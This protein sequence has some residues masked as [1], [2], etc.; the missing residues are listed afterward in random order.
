MTNKATPIN[1]I[2]YDGGLV[3]LLDNVPYY[4]HINDS[5]PSGYY[6]QYEKFINGGYQKTTTNGATIHWVKNKETDMWSILTDG[7]T[8]YIGIQQYND[9]PITFAVSKKSNKKTPKNEDSVTTAMNTIA[10]SLGSV[11]TQYAIPKESETTKVQSFGKKMASTSKTSKHKP[12]LQST[13]HNVAVKQQNANN[14]PVVKGKTKSGNYKYDYT[15]S[16]QQSIKDDIDK[17]KKNLNA[18]SAYSRLELNKLFHKKFNRFRIQFPD[19]FLHNTTPCVIFTRPDLNL[20]D[21]DGVMLDQVA[22]DPQFYYIMR[23]DLLT[24]KTLTKSFTGEHHFNPLLSNII[25]SLDIQ[26]ESIDLMETGETFTGFKTQYAKSNIRSLTANTMNIRFPE[27]Y[28]MSITHCHQLWCTYESNVFRGVMKPKMKYVWNKELDYACD[29]YYFLLDTEDSI[30][31]YWCKYTGC[32]PVSVPKSVFSYDN[33]TVINHPEL[34]ITYAY[35]AREDLDLRTLNEFNNNAGGKTSG[36]R[37][38]AD[39]IPELG[40][41]GKTWSGAPFVET[42]YRQNGTGIKSELYALRY[43]QNLVN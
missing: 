12:V 14:Y 13:N 36:F 31:R 32:F 27:T 37:Y 40:S 22:N 9:I 21:S 29:I 5:T 7:T 18:P 42:V 8:V 26:D 4:E 38:R 23:S 17:I 19:Y 11:T 43:R 33:G 28:N 1:I 20:F 15:I 25:S 41:G 3:S 2:P 39:Y 16:I 6:K 10:T 24:A 35:Y 34:N 30:I